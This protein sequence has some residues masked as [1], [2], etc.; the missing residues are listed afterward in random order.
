M[1]T[2]YFL[3][4]E[5][6]LNENIAAFQNVLQKLWPNSNLSY[7]V[8]TNSLPWILKYVKEK[9]GV[10]EV[11][12]DEEYQLAK[13]CGY[14]DNQIVFNGPIKGEKQFASA[15]TGGAYINLDSAKDLEYISRFKG[16]SSENIGIRV[17]VNPAVFS[18]EDIG[19]END[20][21]RF[22]FSVEN[23]EFEKALKAVWSVYGNGKIGL[24]LHCN[25]ITRSL[26]VYKSIAQYA[27]KLIQK[28]NLELSFIDM[29]GGYFGGVEG[30]PTPE[31][32]VTVI[33]NELCVAVNPEVTKLIVEPGSAII[34]S[35]IELHTSVL[36]VKDTTC[37][38]IVTTDGSR[39]H[40][41]PLWAKSRYM[42]STN[43]KETRNHPRQIICGYTCMDHDRI[44]VLENE[45]ELCVG[46]EVIYHRVG[47]YSITFGGMFIR[48]YP[49][50]YV[51]NDMG[52]EKVRSR[53][54]VDDYIK[55][56]S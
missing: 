54:S 7:S 8:K 44:M 33:K 46:D 3:I 10:A 43:A 23:G 49:D 36:D 17:N 38:R 29:G 15:V 18:H 16:K 53:I 48:Y 40:I 32:Y 2:P 39:I 45:K 30:K 14:A 31:D 6:G 5:N 12:S 25:S 34:G 52:T 56:H 11:V 37:A 55:I 13:L 50:V 26:N 1:K 35:I 24:H 28:Y 21:F 27:V 4:N 42:F 51:K 9:D 22:G 20:G 47:A 19:Y 41:D